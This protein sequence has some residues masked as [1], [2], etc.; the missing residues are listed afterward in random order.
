M[1]RKYW[2]F[3]LFLLVFS[4]A[5]AQ[6]ALSKGDWIG[7]G[8]IGTTVSPTLFLISPQIEYVYQRNLFVGPLIQAGMG[9]GGALIGTS[10]TGRLH[11]GQH[12]RLRPFLEAGAGVMASNKLFTASLGLLFHMGMGFD[13]LLEERLAISTVIRANFAPPI[14]SFIFSW[15]MVV[16]RFIL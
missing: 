6:A 15:P 7:S 1:V 11:L 13:Y 12:P 8:G 4:C 2:S 16:V 14:Q 9:Q 10:F 5:P 3:F